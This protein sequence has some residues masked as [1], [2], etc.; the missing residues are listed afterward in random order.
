V[1][2]HEITA[3]SPLKDWITHDGM[4]KVGGVVGW[5]CVC[6]VGGGG[7]WVGGGWGGGGGGLLVSPM[8]CVI[9]NEF[10]TSQ[11]RCRC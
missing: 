7:K 6:V 1:V 10:V 2:G 9:P 8:L 5:V 11:A 4:L 3:D